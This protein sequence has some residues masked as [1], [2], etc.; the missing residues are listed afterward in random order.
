VVVQGDMHGDITSQTSES[1]TNIVQKGDSSTVQT[2]QGGE[3]GPPAEPESK[4]MKIA[5]AVAF[6]IG[7]VLIVLAATGTIEQKAGFGGGLILVGG[8]AGLPGALRILGVGGS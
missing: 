3:E 5:R 4:F 1:G 2:G 7:V 8:S 6:C